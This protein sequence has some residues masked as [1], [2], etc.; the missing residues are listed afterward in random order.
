[1]H[2]QIESIVCERVQVG[3]WVYVWYVV[4]AVSVGIIDRIYVTHASGHYHILF[5]HP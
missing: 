1:M 4:G 2:R 3:A 5:R